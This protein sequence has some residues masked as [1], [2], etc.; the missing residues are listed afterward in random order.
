MVVLLLAT[1]ATA[2]AVLTPAYGN[3]AQRSLLVDELQ[4]QSVRATQLQVYDT[5]NAL[6][7]SPLTEATGRIH[8]RIAQYPAMAVYTDPID[9]VRA[10]VA[11]T[12]GRYDARTN[13]AYRQDV[14][15]HVALVAGE[16]VT[17]PQ[18]VLISRRSAAA[19]RVTVGDVLT[20][21]APQHGDE[22]RVEHEI[23]GVYEPVDAADDGFWGRSGYFGHGPD[24]DGVEYL[25][26][27]LV[28]DPEAVG[29]AVTEEVR[30]GVDY[31]L[32]IPALRDGDIDAVLA[33]LKDLEVDGA[34]P[35]E[36]ALTVDGNLVGIIDAIRVGQ[37]DIRASVPIVA[38]PLL[39]LCWFVLYMAVARVTDD[40]APEMG[41]AKLRGLR[42]RSV[43]VFALGESMLLIVVALP[44]GILLGMGVV[45]ITAGLALADGVTVTLTLSVFG[46]A[47]LAMIGSLVAV[48]AATRG[49]VRRGVLDLLKR[50]PGRVRWRVGILEGAVAAAAIAATVQALTG[51]SGPIAMLAPALVAVVAGLAAARVLGFLARFRLRRAKRAGAVPRILAMVQLAR[52]PEHRRVVVLLTVALTLLT[53]G[54]AAWDLSER[55]RGLVASDAL[56]AN[57]V[58]QVEVSAPTQLR[59]IVEAL[60]PDGEHLMGVMRT[61]ERYSSENFLVIAAQTDRMAQVMRW[62]D[63]DR[64]DLAELATKLHPAASDPVQVHDELAVTVS[65]DRADADRPLELSARIV[66]PGE[67]PRNILMGQLEVG[68]SDYRVDLPDCDDGCRL[69]GIGVT[70]YP[71]DFSE[72]SFSLTVHTMADAAG[73]LSF[74]SDSQWH[75][76]GLTPRNAPFNVDLTETGLAMSSVNANAPELIAEHMTAPSPLPAVLA[77]PAPDDD[78]D[79]PRFWF[80]A[81][82]GRPQFFETVDTDVLVPRGGERALLVDLEYTERI[83]ETFTDL[84]TRNDILYEVWANDTAPADLERQLNDAGVSVSGYTDRAE[85]LDRLSRQPPALALRLYLLAGGAALVLA[86]GVV[87]LT[88]T[89]GSR[90]RRVDDA[91]LRLSGIGHVVLRR[92]AII[93][94]VHWA[95]L[96]LV[97]GVVAG[98]VS[99]GLVLPSVPLVADDVVGPVD[100]RLGMWW[101]PSAVLVA[102]VALVATVTL[103][104]WSRRRGGTVGRLHDGRT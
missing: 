63:H 74:L 23:V 80:P 71:G 48:V 89:A 25:D 14:C 50:V 11:V 100:Y 84:A 54:V 24:P 16:C 31:H 8:D 103:A 35:G 15:E 20:L 90:W 69:I 86:V 38:V 92:S 59:A 62:R 26:A 57:A 68:R 13:L 58:Y 88:A 96:P 64:A 17:G 49:A 5:W 55:N 28:T 45:A 79:A 82:H 37:A 22:E 85:L 60:D 102:A 27:L 99:A 46:Y 30:V 32:D 77:G 94:Y 29:G 73:P 34:E 81:A 41:L 43:A 101:L 42:Y 76:S 61:V 18:E 52:R 67:A 9:F 53:F 51:D 104:W 3:A 12:G 47:A 21:L 2:A 97:A 72:V 7:R 40:R 66:E 1:A 10:S 95:G 91:A 39:V 4:Y 87:A 36:P 75:P 78:V 33:A 44:L 93:E 70:R 98:L 6:N 19:Q 56:G 65:T 83:A